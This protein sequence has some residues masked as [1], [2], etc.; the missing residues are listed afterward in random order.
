MGTWNGKFPVT[1]RQKQS[2]PPLVRFLSA[3]QQSA[4]GLVPF[5]VLLVRKFKHGVTLVTIAGVHPEL[6]WP[7]TGKITTNKEI[8]RRR[9][10][11]EKEEENSMVYKEEIPE[12][13]RWLGYWE[14]VDD[15]KRKK[16]WSD[17]IDGG[18]FEFGLGGSTTLTNVCERK[19]SLVCH[20]YCFVGAHFDLEPRAVDVSL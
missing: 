10:R 9:T 6:V 17:F 18:K 12:Y 4:L 16:R 20:V 14:M 19:M 3:P 15:G 7:W 13:F 2:L 8:P 11:R 5:P 1:M